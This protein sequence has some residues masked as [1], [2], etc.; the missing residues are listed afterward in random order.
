MKRKLQRKIFKLVSLLEPP[1]WRTVHTE[2]ISTEDIEQFKRV[3]GI[4]TLKYDLSDLNKSRIVI[5]EGPAHGSVA[6]PARVAGLL[7]VETRK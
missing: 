6:D 4:D 3:V 1:K 2:W 7:V 5:Y